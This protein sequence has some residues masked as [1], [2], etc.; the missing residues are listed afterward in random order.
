MAFLKN[1][2]HQELVYTS[3]RV[4]TAEESAGCGSSF[5][6]QLTN[7]CHGEGREGKIT[8]LPLSPHSDYDF[9]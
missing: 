2:K 7:E 1:K 3:L 5:C 6:W 4:R 8:T 9:H